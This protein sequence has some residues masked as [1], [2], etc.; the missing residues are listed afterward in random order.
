LEIN[1]VV[2][3][4]FAQGSFTLLLP[5]K[6]GMCAQRKK[7]G[8]MFPQQTHKPGLLIAVVP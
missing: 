5:Q 8:G 3:Y 4:V 6:G 1:I 2:T 7:K